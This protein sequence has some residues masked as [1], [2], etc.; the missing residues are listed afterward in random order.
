MVPR[1]FFD[2][3]YACSDIY[4]RALDNSGIDTSYLKFDPTY[5]SGIRVDL[6]PEPASLGLLAAGAGALGLT[7]RL[8]RKAELARER[9]DKLAGIRRR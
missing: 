4:F 7:R 6:S 9:T 8:R 1:C 5:S 3:S 2:S